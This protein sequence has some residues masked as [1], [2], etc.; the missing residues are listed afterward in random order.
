MAT[1]QNPNQNQNQEP[2]Q[3]MNQGQGQKQAQP[4]GQ[5]QMNKGRQDF[6]GGMDQQQDEDQIGNRSGQSIPANQKSSQ[7]DT[8]V[9]K[10]ANPKKQ[11]K[12]WESQDEFSGGNEDLKNDV[13]EKNPKENS[14]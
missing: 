3:N 1:N 4:Q 10:N 5:G 13:S 9:M 7:Q 14:H 6:S 8:S 11:D 2:K 12:Q